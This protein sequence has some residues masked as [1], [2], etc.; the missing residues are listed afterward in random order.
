MATRKPKNDGKTSKT[1]T[2]IE[3]LGGIKCNVCD[4]VL[5]TKFNFDRHYK[6]HGHENIVYTCLACRAEIA[7]Y[8]TFI[9][10]CYRHTL[11][12]RL[13]CQI[14]K[15]HYS[16]SQ[17]LLDHLKNIHGLGQYV[18]PSPCNQVFNNLSEFKKHMDDTHKKINKTQNC[19][20]CQTELPTQESCLEHLDAHVEFIFSCPICG[21]QFGDRDDAPEHLHTHF[22][23]EILNLHELT[24][25]EVAYTPGNPV[26]ISCGVCRVAFKTKAD[27]EAHYTS[28]HDT[29]I[30]YTCAVCWKN[31]KQYNIFSNHCYNHLVKGKFKCDVCQKTFPRLPMLVVHMETV[32]ISA[33]NNEK[34]FECVECKQRFSI[35]KSLKAH[36][37]DNHG[38][39]YQICSF[40][41]CGKMF[42][43]PTALI[44]HEIEH[45]SR[46]QQR[47]SNCGLLFK[48]LFACYK[49]MDVHKIIKFNCPICE[50]KYSEKYLIVKHLKDHYQG[51]MHVCQKCGKVYN[52]RYRLM[53]HIKIHT[54]ETLSCSYCE[55][56]FSTRP[57]LNDHVNTHTKETPYKCLVCPK[58][59][60]SESG[61][62][63]HLKNLHNVTSIKKTDMFGVNSIADIGPGT[64]DA[65][66][67]D[68]EFNILD[69][70]DK[71]VDES[72]EVVE[73]NAIAET[74]GAE[75]M[76]PVESECILDLDARKYDED[77]PSE[78]KEEPA[79]EMPNFID[80]SC[81]TSY[82]NQVVYHTVYP[83]KIMENVTFNDNDYQTDYEM[84]LPYAVL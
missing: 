58:R 30:T 80:T 70:D 64:D 31:Y 51:D 63:K 5:Q 56:K 35:G 7:S 44:S 21:V 48:N 25:Y 60:P 50:R 22:Q 28:Q 8:K 34:P 19:V 81:E 57:R 71:I 49:H 61:W 54:Q 66:P 46:P 10:H 12:S 38:V 1:S 83:T 29:T 55:K 26:Q 36:L 62:R 42:D 39:S 18:C 69:T 20:L 72:E 59:F 2:C 75:L 4:A 32:H 43:S 65:M 45:R 78:A 11:K 53:Q 15:K 17:A 79:E 52:R 23:D 84:V 74:I 41:G 76:E 14:C 6:K 40:P 9:D 3:Q 24:K 67:C 82:G 77:E 33:V 47:C 27:F 16:K 73:I 68:D 37:Q 13:E